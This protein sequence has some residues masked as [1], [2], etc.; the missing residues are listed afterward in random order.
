MTPMDLAGLGGS[1]KH[2]EITMMVSH[3]NSD[4][5]CERFLC[6]AKVQKETELSLF[7]QLFRLKRTVP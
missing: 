4:K 5:F 6:K 2:L 7:L 1:R 3:L